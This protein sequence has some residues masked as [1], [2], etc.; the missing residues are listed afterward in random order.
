MRHPN[1][2]HLC[3]YIGL[4]QDCA[5]WGEDWEDLDKQGQFNVHGGITYC[6]LEVLWTDLKPE[7]PRLKDTQWVGFD[8]AHVGDYSPWLGNSFGNEV[9][10]THEYV[11]G[12]VES[13]A[14][15]FLE[16]HQ[17]RIGALKSWHGDSN[18]S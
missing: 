17:T 3:G 18:E 11:K 13:L 1:F 14:A 8:C 9:Y 12:E 16:W 7:D 10:R 15:Q 5:A 6:S 4:P 2:G